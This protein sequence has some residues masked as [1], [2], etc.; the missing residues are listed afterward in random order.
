MGWAVHQRSRER[1]KP[2]LKRQTGKP[3]LPRNSYTGHLTR[4]TAEGRGPPASTQ[5]M[6]DRRP[7]TSPPQA[8]LVLFVTLYPEADSRRG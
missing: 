3:V 2:S 8:G 7:L 6:L 1:N 4:K 5:E